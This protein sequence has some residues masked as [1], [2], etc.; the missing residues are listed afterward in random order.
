MDIVRGYSKGIIEYEGV[1]DIA[2][3]FG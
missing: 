3:H 1:K 2:E